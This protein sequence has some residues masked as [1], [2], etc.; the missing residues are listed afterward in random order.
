M[1]FIKIRWNNT[2]SLFSFSILSFAMTFGR[3]EL[4]PKFPHLLGIRFLESLPVYH[5]S[6]INPSITMEKG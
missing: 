1:D 4:W 6:L 2:N 5:I 3:I